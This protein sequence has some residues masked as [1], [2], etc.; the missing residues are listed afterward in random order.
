MLFE[1]I[2]GIVISILCVLII[3]KIRPQ[4]DQDFWRLGLFIAALIYVGFVIINGAWSYFL[5]ELGG[6]LF[7]GLFIWLS[8]KYDLYWLG[9]G[10]ALHIGWD[11][12]LHSGTETSYTPEWYPGVC[13]GFDIIIA[14]YII[15]IYYLK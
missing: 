3:A 6:V 14:I 5:L 11:V 15:S 2:I 8:R 13:V 10:W 12:L 4:K 7:Y 1:I 9:I